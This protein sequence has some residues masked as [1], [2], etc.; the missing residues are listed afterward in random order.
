MNKYIIFMLSKVSVLFPGERGRGITEVTCYVIL[1]N[2]TPSPTTADD[3]T[4]RNV[5]YVNSTSHLTHLAHCLVPAQPHL[6]FWQRRI[7]MSPLERQSAPP[8]QSW[9]RPQ[10]SRSIIVGAVTTWD[11]ETQVVEDFASSLT[12]DL[13]LH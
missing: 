13:V 1:C 2:A 12:P 5:N 8:R 7:P 11:N 3:I 10:S 9:F 4:R 6:L